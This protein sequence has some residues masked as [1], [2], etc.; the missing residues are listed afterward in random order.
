MVWPAPPKGEGRADQRT[1]LLP[2]RPGAAKGPVDNHALVLVIAS[3]YE[4]VAVEDIVVT[5][6]LG[7]LIECRVQLLSLIPYPYEVIDQISSED[8]AR[9]GMVGNRWKRL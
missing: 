6:R 8:S 1:Q 9:D 2:D 5:E 7:Q 4:Q 3:T